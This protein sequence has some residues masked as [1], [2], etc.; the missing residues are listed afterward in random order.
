M[1]VISFKP[2]DKGKIASN[3]KEGK[4]AGEYTAIAFTP[5]GIKTPVTLRLYHNGQGIIKYACIWI[6]D[7]PREQYTSGGGHAHGYGYHHASAATAEAIENAGIK[8]S[9]PISGRGEGAIESA[10]MAIARYI[11]PDVNIYIHH[12]HG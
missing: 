12:A 8:L 4:F 3:R 7:T 2:T 1:Q 6:F 9:D 10:V 11:Y 5:A